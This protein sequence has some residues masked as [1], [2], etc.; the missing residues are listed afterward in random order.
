MLVAWVSQSA[1]RP[2]NGEYEI[3]ASKGATNRAEFSRSSLKGIP[4][5][6]GGELFRIFLDRQ[7]C[8]REYLARGGRAAGARVAQW[9]EGGGEGPPEVE[10]RTKSAAHAQ[11]PGPA[12]PSARRQRT[13]R[14]KLLLTAAKCSG[15]SGPCCYDLNL[16]GSSRA[17]C[18]P[19]R[20]G[21]SSFSTSCRKRPSEC[22][23]IIRQVFRH[24]SKCFFYYP[25][26]SVISYIFAGTL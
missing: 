10:D 1:D 17:F 18:G 13:L 2:T 11:T 8:A 20:G 9:E 14:W 4:F 19:R 15:Y 24:F 7:R 6:F 3:T 5:I 23:R 22:E 21:P 25:P 26:A 16:S 12:L